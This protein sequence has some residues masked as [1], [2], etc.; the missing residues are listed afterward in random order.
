M[1]PWTE[2]EEHEEPSRFFNPFH[3]LSQDLKTHKLSKYPDLILSNLRNTLSASI[4]LKR[5]IYMHHASRNL[6]ISHSI[7]FAFV[8]TVSQIRCISASL[9]PRSIVCL[10]ICFL[11]PII[12]AFV[13]PGI[14]LTRHRCIFNPCILPYMLQFC[15]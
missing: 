8:Y 11:H 5:Y 12:L 7:Y 6:W 4:D 14:S 9:H 15:V 2:A 13:H 10:D 3:D 1:Y